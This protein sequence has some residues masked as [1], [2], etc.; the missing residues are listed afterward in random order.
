MYVYVC[1]VYACI[2]IMLIYRYFCKI[3]S[4]KNVRPKL[5]GFHILKA[6][7]K[8]SPINII[9]IYTPI[10]NILECYLLH[11]FNQHWYIVVICIYIF[12]YEWDIAFF[13]YVLTT[14]IFSVY[15]FVPLFCPI[16]HSY[17]FQTIY[18]EII[19]MSIICVVNYM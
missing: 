12:N 8:F 18:N 10:N 5:N 4:Q 19:P 2:F 11:T 13:T 3:H 15:S 17:V 9:P 16:F 1:V 7:T 14:Y 6:S